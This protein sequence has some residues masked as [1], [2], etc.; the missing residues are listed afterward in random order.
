MYVTKD[1]QLEEEYEQC[2]NKLYKANLEAHDIVPNISGG[3]VFVKRF[4]K[5]TEMEKSLSKK[6]QE[7][8]LPA[9][10]KVERNMPIPAEPTEDDFKE[11]QQ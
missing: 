11:A 10:K 3:H 9:P 6:V 1:W 2:V 7:A 8:A 5:R 4:V